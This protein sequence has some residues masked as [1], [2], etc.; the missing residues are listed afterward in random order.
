MTTYTRLTK[1]EARLWISEAWGRDISINNVKLRGDWLFVRD[2][3][4]DEDE[5][6]CIYRPKSGDLSGEPWDM[7]RLADS[8]FVPHNDEAVAIAVAKLDA[9]MAKVE[10]EKRVQ[11]EAEEALFATYWVSCVWAE[12]RVCR[13]DDYPTYEEA[14]G[15]AIGRA[16]SRYGEGWL[17][18]NRH[19]NPPRRDTN[20]FL[21]GDKQGGYSIISYPQLG[22]F[23]AETGFAFENEVDKG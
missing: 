15:Y 9:A 12:G 16:E 7:V 18:A 14:F 21:A 6:E 2:P 17:Q 19:D 23:D 22:D 4:E 10:E 5:V 20:T 1:A 3:E 13:I 11:R 8:P